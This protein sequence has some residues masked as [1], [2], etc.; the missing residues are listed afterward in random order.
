MGLR[1]G[2][3]ALEKAGLSDLG[4]EDLGLSA[5]VRLPAQRSCRRGPG[6]HGLG[7]GWQGGNRP[8]TGPCLVGNRGPRRL[9]AAG[10]ASVVEGGQA[11]G[12]G[13]SP[14]ALPLLEAGVGKDTGAWLGGQGVR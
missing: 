1:A 12:T 5:P 4:V 9:G 11:R 13:S 14:T 3:R 6:G 7:R 10:G 2:G 8:R